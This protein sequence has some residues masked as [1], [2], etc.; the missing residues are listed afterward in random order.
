MSESL[1]REVGY[2]GI[3]VIIVE[4]GFF[5]S[6]FVDNFSLPGE[7]WS[8]AYKTG[9]AQECLDRMMAMNG[10]GTGDVRKGCQV[11]YEAVTNTGRGKGM[12]DFMRLILGKDAA[13]RVRDKGR[14]LLDT[15]EGTEDLWSSTDHDDIS[16]SG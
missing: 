7:G 15:V 2:F 6:D 12:E 11:I 4:A 5:R 1:S 14:N 13:M 3:R 10:K 9:P 8:E 16:K